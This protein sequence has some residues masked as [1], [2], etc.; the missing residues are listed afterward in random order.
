MSMEVK[1]SVNDTHITSLNITNITEKPTGV[2]RYRWIYS[3][4]DIGNVKGLLSAQAG[5]VE[6]NYED[7]AMALIAKVAQAASETEVSA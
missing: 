7:G 4:H 2:N 6:H 3:R 5:Y 1:V